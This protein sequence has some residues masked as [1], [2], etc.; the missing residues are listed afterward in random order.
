MTQNSNS[1]GAFANCNTDQKPDFKKCLNQN[2]EN[3]MKNRAQ[4]QAMLH[5]HYHTDKK[6][7]YMIYKILKDREKSVKSREQDHSPTIDHS[8]PVISRVC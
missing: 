7:K 8:S 5:N 6:D 2:F 3:K 4:S 1:T